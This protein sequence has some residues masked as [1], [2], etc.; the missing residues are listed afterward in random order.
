MRWPFTVKFEQLITYTH[1]YIYCIES[2]Y[3]IIYRYVQ[4]CIYTYNGNLNEIKN[5]NTI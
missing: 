4:Y 3:N 2:I 5:Y 1:A